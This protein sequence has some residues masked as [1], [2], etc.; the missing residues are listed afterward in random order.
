M[1][2]KDWFA[3][4]FSLWSCTVATIALIVNIKGKKKNRSRKP[5]KSKRKR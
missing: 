4:F 5:T 1:E 3:T 2:L